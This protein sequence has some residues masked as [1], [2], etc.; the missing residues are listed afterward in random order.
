MGKKPVPGKITEAY[1]L[2][3]RLLSKQL[4]SEDITAEHF[5]TALQ[6][7]NVAIIELSEEPYKG[8][9]PQVIFET[10]NSLGKPLSL[11]DLIRN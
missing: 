1:N 8:E 3:I 2:F 7:I 11:S 5:I 4:E 9:D 6:R 10:L